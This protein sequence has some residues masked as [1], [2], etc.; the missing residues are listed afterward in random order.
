MGHMNITS[1]KYTKLQIVW[2]L[3]LIRLSCFYSMEVSKLPPHHPTP[4]CISIDLS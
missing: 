4:S 3:M 2:M 1:E